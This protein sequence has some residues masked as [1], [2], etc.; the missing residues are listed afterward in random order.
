MSLMVGNVGTMFDKTR[1][2]TVCCVLL[3]R[4]LMTP[5]VESKINTKKLITLRLKLSAGEICQRLI[6]NDH[7]SWNNIEARSY[8]ECQKKYFYKIELQILNLRS[9]GRKED[10]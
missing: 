5:N 8:V 9:M 10:A 7:S 1:T 3:V 2:I 6:N 4:T